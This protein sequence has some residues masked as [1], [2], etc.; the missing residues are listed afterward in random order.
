METRP[1]LFGQA[2]ASEVQMQSILP[3]EIPGNREVVDFA[4]E[5]AEK[6]GALNATVR[7]FSRT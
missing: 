1:H 5:R 2:Q 3:V 7:I 6:S 4:T